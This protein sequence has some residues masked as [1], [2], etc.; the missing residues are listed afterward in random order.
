MG[1][2]L[3]F[4]RYVTID[5]PYK[6]MAEQ[7]TLC[8]RLGLRGR[9]II[10]HEGINGTLGGSVEAA[11]EYVAI[12]RADRRFADVDFKES[13]GGAEYFPR[14]RIV[15]KNEIVHLGV[16]TEK[17]DPQQGGLHLTPV[18]VHELLEEYEED[19][20]EEEDDLVIL[21]TRNMYES[22]IGAFKHAHKAPINNFRELPAYIDEH[23]EEFKNKRVLMY[24][25]GG[26]RCERAT[27]YLAQKGVA[28]QVMQIQG[29]IQRYVEEFPNG[30]FRGKNYQFDARIACRVNDDILTTCD[31]CAI[32][33]DD[34]A[35]CANA[36]CN[37]QIILCTPCMNNFKSTC[38]DA[39]LELVHNKRVVVRTTPRTQLHESCGI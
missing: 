5:D 27:A 26:V 36:E 3:L 30:F 18:E 8:S 12:M 13:Q 16:P 14:L 25:T 17:A 7:R 34:Y 37:K 29:G 28:K 1:K 9:V 39:C 10:A 35:N 22:R 38:T 24:C 20:D 23:L 31:R 21:D 4:Y 33:C 19:I 6:L 2:I 11:E 32:P 15:V